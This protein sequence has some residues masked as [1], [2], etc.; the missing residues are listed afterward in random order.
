MAERIGLD[1]PFRL[2]H[3]AVGIPLSTRNDLSML[4]V[5]NLLCVEPMDRYNTV[6]D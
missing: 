3:C 4:R 2:F 6:T 5:P 1:S